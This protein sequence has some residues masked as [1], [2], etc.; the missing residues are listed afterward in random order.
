MGL[1]PP[2]NLGFG[3]DDAKFPVAHLSKGL[4]RFAYLSSHELVSYLTDLSSLLRRDGEAQ[5]RVTAQTAAL[6]VE[7]VDADAMHEGAV[8][9]Y[10]KTLVHQCF[11]NDFT[12]FFTVS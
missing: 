3:N 12:D 11:F 5:G 10:F 4:N 6:P 2:G 7:T 1:P 9:D 8:P